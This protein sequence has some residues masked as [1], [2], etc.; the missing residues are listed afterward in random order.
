LRTEF[1]YDGFGRRTQLVEKNNGTVTSTKKFIWSGMQLCEEL[2]GNNTV[3]KRFYRDGEQIGTASYYFTR[4]HLGSVREMTDNS[5]TIVARYDYDPYG[6]RGPNQI[7]SGAVEADF[8]FTGYYVHAPSGLHLALYRAYDADTGRW[9]NRDPIEEEGGLNLYV[10]VSNDSINMVDPLGLVDCALLESF[11]FRTEH[12]ISEAIHSMSDINKMFNSAKNM[13]WMALAGDIAYALVGG[14]TM[15]DN[16]AAYE[17][18]VFKP[19][20]GVAGATAGGIFDVTV[21]EASLRIPNA[22]PQMIS[23]IN[24]LNLADTAAELDETIAENMSTSTYQTIQRSQSQ[25]RN[26]LNM[27]NSICKCKQ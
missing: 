22:L 15:Y 11:I 17:V 8:G 24:L 19:A 26:M 27:F 13:Q 16:L 7:T 10:Y 25:L 2:D 20:G 1:T 14:Y 18:N 9:I 3:T 23:G 5:G 6:R 12:N 21:D 4:D